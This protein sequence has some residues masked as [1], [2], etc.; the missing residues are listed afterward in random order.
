MP[1]PSFPVTKILAAATVAVAMF[2]ASACGGSDDEDPPASSQ[3]ADTTQTAETQADS[4]DESQAAGGQD[5][6]PDGGGQ[7]APDTQSGATGGGES[8][9]APN[10]DDAR[11]ERDRVADVVAGMYRNFSRA[12]A[13]GVCAAMSN[14]AREEIAAGAKGT[15]ASPDAKGTCADTLSRLLS[16]AGAVAMLERTLAAR[17]TAVSIDGSTATAQVSFGGPSG[18]VKLIKEQGEW[19]FG[20]DALAPPS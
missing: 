16:S 13:E 18:A 15:L 7:A 12:N 2:A 10:G 8:S 9:S 1:L 5:E 19:R 6:V 17:V 11:D 20:T 3:S 4:P 14:K